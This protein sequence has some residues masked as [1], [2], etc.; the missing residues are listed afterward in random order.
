VTLARS[1]TANR[2]ARGVVWILLVAILTFSALHGQ[3]PDPSRSKALSRRV[4]DRARALEDKTAQLAGQAKTLLGEL[5]QLETERDVQVEHSRKALAASREAAAALD[6]TIA[7]LTDLEQRRVGELPGLH[8]RLV[9]LYKQGRGGYA[10]LLLNA[11]D[12]Q[13]V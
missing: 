1:P 9:E 4:S 3:E 11:R 7:R 12:L 5:R 13:E 8:A 6:D 2:H 10:R